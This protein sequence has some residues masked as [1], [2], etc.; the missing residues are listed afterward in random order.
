MGVNMVI[1]EQDIGFVFNISSRNYV[2]SKGKII[3]EGGADDLLADERI[4]KIYL[5]L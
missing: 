2:M 3:A 4:R 5:G 1:V